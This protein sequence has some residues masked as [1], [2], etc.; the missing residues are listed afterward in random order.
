MRP[1][2]IAA[3]TGSVFGV[4]L[5][6]TGCGSSSAHVRLLNT[7]PVQ[8][9]IDMLIDGKDVASS[10]PFGAASP[11]VTVSSGSR[12][13]QVESSGS[14]S[15][16]VDQNITVSSGSDTTVFE[17]IAGPMIL[18]DNNKTPSSGNFNL[19]IINASSQIGTADVYIVTSG[20]GIG[21]TPTISSLKYPSASGYQTLTGGSYQIILTSPGNSNV[22]LTTSAM[23]FSSGQVRTIVIMDGQTG[24]VTTAVIAD[25]N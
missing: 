4:I 17:G 1:I 13:L 12:H 7:L 5:F 3:V 15:P 10:I 20:S 16:F 24:G 21:T 8:S 19:R 23:S 9:N 14:S 18:T 22:E 25:A 11:Y 2:S 6:A